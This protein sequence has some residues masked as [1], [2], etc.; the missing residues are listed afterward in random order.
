MKKNPFL[1]IMLLPMLVVLSFLSVSCGGD[2][3]DNGNPISDGISA[4]SPDGTKGTYKGR[5]CIVVTLNGKK[6]AVATKNLG[7]QEETDYGNYYSFDETTNPTTIGLSASATEWHVPTKEEL[8]S[9][10]NLA[11][12][13][14][15]LNDVNG[16]RWTV[17]TSSLFFPAA[18]NYGYL[19]GDFGYYWSSTE[20]N[21]EKTYYMLFTNT[22]CNISIENR[23]T[24]ISVRP[25]CALTK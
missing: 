17:G 2:D 11:N 16:R 21:A 12:E 15:T 23:T 8:E 19:Q 25:F 6:Y 22:N 20:K 24:S 14:V 9:F 5:E 4:N 13:W 3:D 1:K 10:A 7:A 18:G